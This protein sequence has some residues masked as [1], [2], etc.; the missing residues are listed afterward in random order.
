MVF[1][2]YI[3]FCEKCIWDQNLTFTTPWANSADEK[4]VI[5]SLFPRKQ[6]LKFHANCLQHANCLKTCFLGKIRKKIFQC[7][8]LNFLPRVLSVNIMTRHSMPFIFVSN[9]IIKFLYLSQ[10]STHAFQLSHLLACVHIQY[11]NV[12]HVYP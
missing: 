9:P 8:L 10:T 4:L 7:C 2:V 1:N 11:C 12:R 3:C 5:S 6:D